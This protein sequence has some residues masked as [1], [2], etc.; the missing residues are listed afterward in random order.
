MGDS[1]TGLTCDSWASG[2]NRRRRD[3]AQ[4]WRSLFARF[5]GTGAG[6]SG[7]RC[8]R[9]RDRQ[10]IARHLVLRLEG[11]GPPACYGRTDRLAATRHVPPKLAPLYGAIRRQV[12]ERPDMTLAELRAWLLEAHKTA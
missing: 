12:A 5:A 3:A 4:A 9:R 8:C 10:G 2:S 11:L 1:E 6:Q 7:G